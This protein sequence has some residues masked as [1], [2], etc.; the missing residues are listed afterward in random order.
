VRTPEGLALLDL[1]TMALGDPAGDVGRFLAYEHVRTARAGSGT[2]TPATSAAAAARSTTRTGNAFLTAYDPGTGATD[3]TALDARVWA[4]RR[5]DL[6]VIALRAA[7]RLKGARS[8]IALDLLGDS[9]PAPATRPSDVPPG[10][11]P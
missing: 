8:A 3:P 4:H 7:R 9:D 10:R 2:A 1:D 6:V 5:L 11:H